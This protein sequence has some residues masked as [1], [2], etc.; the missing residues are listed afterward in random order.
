MIDSCI[1]SVESQKS[2]P[3]KYIS[4]IGDLIL[5]LDESGHRIEV[6]DRVR[7]MFDSQFKLSY[8]EA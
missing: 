4:D 7:G 6:N 3:G 2:T 8:L 1:H 5:C